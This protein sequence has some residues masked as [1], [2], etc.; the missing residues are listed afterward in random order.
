M[1]CWPEQKKVAIRRGS[2]VFEEVYSGRPYA[3]FLC[4][5]FIVHCTSND[6]AL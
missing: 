6:K 4:L 5:K 1:D 2:T 3:I